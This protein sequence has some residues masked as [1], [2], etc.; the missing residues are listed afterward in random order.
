MTLDDVRIHIDSVDREL[1]QLIEKRMSLAYE[2]AQTKLESGD[3]I[4]KPDRE[5]LIISRL[6]QNTRPDILQEYRA[7]IKKIM[8]VSREYQYSITMNHKNYCPITYSSAPDPDD[9]RE[10]IIDREAYNNIDAVLRELAAGNR[11][12]NNFIRHDNNT[13]LI[14][15]SGQLAGNDKTRYILV[16]IDSP[17]YISM[18]ANILGIASDFD[19]SASWIHTTSQACCIEFAAGITQTVTMVMIYMLISEYDNLRV[20]GSY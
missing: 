16:Y 13:A 17:E 5:Q 7:L 9:I 15:H 10:L 19:I 8:L 6:T 3:N 14:L 12:I 1:R 2:V 11:Y 4:Y 18:I 20:I